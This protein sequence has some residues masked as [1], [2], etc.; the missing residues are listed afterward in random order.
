MLKC[1]SAVRRLLGPKTTCE[2]VVI[3]IENTKQINF[4]QNTD[5]QFF[6]GVR[7]TSQSREP[8]SD[9]DEGLEFTAYSSAQ[10][11][12]AVVKW[13]TERKRDLM[14]A[15]CSLMQMKRSG[16]P[17]GN[18]GCVGQVSTSLFRLF[19]RLLQP[20]LTVTRQSTSSLLQMTLWVFSNINLIPA[21]P[22][23]C[24]YNINTSAD[25]VKLGTVCL[26]V[27]SF[28]YTY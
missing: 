3:W 5:I 20:A 24:K 10:V 6:Y 26:C 14:T 9:T 11:L 7:N 23:R 17:S 13:P 28:I 22:Q 27:A 21:W 25:C 4:Q 8:K 15:R 12:I 1:G 2:S 16:C 18:V 19:F